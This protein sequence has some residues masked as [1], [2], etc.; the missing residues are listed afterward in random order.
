MVHQECV[1]S[2]G[3]TRYATAKLRA[4][5]TKLADQKP[6][7]IGQANSDIVMHSMADTSEG[8]ASTTEKSAPTGF[9]ILG[10]ELKLKSASG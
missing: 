10:V 8:S 7:L 9:V 1:R 6:P 2:G 3:A 5:P 4:D